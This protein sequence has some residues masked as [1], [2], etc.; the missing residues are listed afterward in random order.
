MEA[1]SESSEQ[2]WGGWWRHAFS[3][4]GSVFYDRGAGE[5]CASRMQEACVPALHFQVLSSRTRTDLKKQPRNTEVQAVSAQ[6]QLERTATSAMSCRHRHLQ[7]L[8]WRASI[9]AKAA[10]PCQCG[11]RSRFMKLLYRP[12]PGRGQH[13]HLWKVHGAFSNVT[14]TTNPLI[15]DKCVVS[16]GIWGSMPRVSCET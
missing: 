13:S 8:K 16:G 1:L 10:K 5:I 14:S 12:C 11:S 15:T 2:C 4:A 3:E 6:R 7:L 9:T